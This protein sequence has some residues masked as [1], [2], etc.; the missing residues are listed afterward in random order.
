MDSVPAIYTLVLML[1]KVRSR[2]NRSPLSL[3]AVT[4]GHATT[5][6]PCQVGRMLELVIRPVAGYTGLDAVRN[7]SA[8]A[9]GFSEKITYTTPRLLLGDQVGG[10]V[11]L[12]SQWHALNGKACGVDCV[13]DGAFKRCTPRSGRHFEGGGIAPDQTSRRDVEAGDLCSQQR[14]IQFGRV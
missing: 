8:D 4:V 1:A 14:K 6:Q 10:G 11:Q 7:R 9:S 3:T 5:V 12:R 2:L 13:V